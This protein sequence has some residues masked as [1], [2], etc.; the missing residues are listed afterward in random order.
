MTSQITHL[1]HS[2]RELLLRCAKSWWLKYMTPAPR[3]V[4]LWTAIGS[5]VHEATEK[6][7]R[8]QVNCVEQAFHAGSVWERCFDAQLDG[9]RRKEPDEYKWRFSPSEP[10]GV[11]STLGPQLVQSWI[12]WRQ[13]SPYTVWITPDGVPAIELDVSGMLPGCPVEIQGYIDIVMHDPVF[14]QLVIIDKKTSKKPPAEVAQFATYAALLEVKYGV[15]AR[16]GAAFMKRQGTVAR[17]VEQAEHTPGAIGAAFGE[18]WEQIKAGKVPATPGRACF[19]CDTSSSCAIKNGPLAD[20][21]DPD[22]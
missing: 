9:L 15:R 1:S 12:D 18:A 14:D 22:S 3:S 5:A 10:L 7:D 21:Y 2:S 16:L 13:R 17:P 8:M 20:R 19:L 6:Y 4:S 11:W